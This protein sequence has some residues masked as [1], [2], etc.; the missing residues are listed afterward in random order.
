MQQDIKITE[1]LYR[2]YFTFASTLTS[3]NTPDTQESIYLLTD[4]N[5][6]IPLVM[7][8]QHKFP[9]QISLSELIHLRIR[10]NKIKFLM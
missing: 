6:Q 1:D 2:N 5:T 8:T 9:I 3:Y 10:F 7:C 4:I